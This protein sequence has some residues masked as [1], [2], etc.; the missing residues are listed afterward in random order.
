MEESVMN[1]LLQ[2]GPF[3]ALFVWLLFS[4][5]KE[6][7]DRET[8]LVKQAQAREAK[9]MEHN[10][11]MVTHLERNTATLQQIE[12]SLAELGSDVQELKEKVG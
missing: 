12:R 9:L 1:A 2:Q 4:T 11:R 10:E 6:G 5:K 8:R 3:A 7:R